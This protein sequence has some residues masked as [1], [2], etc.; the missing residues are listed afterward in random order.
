MRPVCAAGRTSWS[1]STTGLRFRCA[2]A[3]V[4]RLRWGPDRLAAAVGGVTLWPGRNLFIVDFG[5]AITL[6]VVTAD[7]VYRGGSI[8]PGLANALPCPARL[9]GT[10]AADRH[11]GV[12]GLP[13]GERYP[14]PRAKRWPWGVIEGIVAEVGEW[15]RRYGRNHAGLVTIF[16]GGDAAFFEKTI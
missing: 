1:I 2:T 8:S 9:H 10:A 11:R 3:T 6:D 7:G 5:S 15:M 13:R 4:R 16:T 14:P 12:S